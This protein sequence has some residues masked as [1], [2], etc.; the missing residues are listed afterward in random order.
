MMRLTILTDGEYPQCEAC[1]GR[2]VDGT[3]FKSIE[4][5][6]KG[7]DV[8]VRELRRVGAEFDSTW[9][10]DDE[11]YFSIHSNHL[12]DRPPEIEVTQDEYR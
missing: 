3:E 12:T 9:G 2:V 6:L 7:Y 4:G 1:V 8:T 5:V 10:D 11:M